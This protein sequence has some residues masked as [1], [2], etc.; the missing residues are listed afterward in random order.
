MKIMFYNS[1]ISSTAFVGE[2]AASYC[3]IKLHILFCQLR[4]QKSYN[5]QSDTDIIQNWHVFCCFHAIKHKAF[6]E[7]QF[8]YFHTQLV[9]VLLSVEMTTKFKGQKKINA[10]LVYYCSPDKKKVS[11]LWPIHDMLLLNHTFIVCNKQSESQVIMAL[12]MT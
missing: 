11:T 1:I 8:H 3:T 6:Q 7:R 5:I 2:L 10:I 12:P 4:I 9:Q